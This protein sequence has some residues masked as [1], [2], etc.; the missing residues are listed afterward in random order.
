MARN[1]EKK[2]QN[3][4]DRRCICRGDKGLYTEEE[5]QRG[6]RQSERSRA[7]KTVGKETERGTQRGK[8]EEDTKWKRYRGRLDRGPK[9]EGRIN[10]ER[11]S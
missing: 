1:R 4:R 5:M 6:E 8:T 9:V 3:E 11:T 7:D 10:S 2:T